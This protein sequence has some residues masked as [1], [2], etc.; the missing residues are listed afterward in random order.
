MFQIFPI[1]IPQT[2]SSEI[3]LLELGIYLLVVLFW[4]AGLGG[5][6]I[7]FEDKF[8]N[9]LLGF[10]LYCLLTGLLLVILGLL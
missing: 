2:N 4:G 5:T 10:F 3:S 8:D 1:I 6:I 7:L 9:P